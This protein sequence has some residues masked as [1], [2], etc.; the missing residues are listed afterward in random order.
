MA[1]KPKQKRARATV[2]AIVRAGF[3]CVAE[4]GMAATTTRHIAEVA[5]VGVGSIYEY[6]R[7]K[8]AIYLAMEKAFMADLAQLITALTPELTEQSIDGVIRLLLHRFRA[9]TEQDDGLYLRYAREAFNTQFRGSQKQ[10]KD[11]LMD[12]LVQYLVR[13]PELAQ[14]K[15]LAGASYF[16][17]YGG[18]FAVM[19]QLMEPSPAVSFDDLVE[20]IAQMAR[21]FSHEQ[22]RAAGLQDGQA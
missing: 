3:I 16:L 8:E 2:D 17:I 20:A 15:N 9:F 7:D 6:F 1:R 11:V 10:L 22:L 18:S 12:I 13:H 4:R 19:S 21:S 14:V 5:G